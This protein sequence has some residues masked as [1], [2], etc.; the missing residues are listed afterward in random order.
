MANPTL[1]VTVQLKDLFSKQFKGMAKG[2]A[3]AA[4]S[5]SR[6][7]GRSFNRVGRSMKTLRTSIGSAGKAFLSLKTAAVAIA[8][9]M[10]GRL[11]RGIVSASTSFEGLSIAMSNLTKEAGMDMIA[12]ME[13]LRVATRGAV[14]DNELM[15][16]TNQA[17]L[18]GVIK[19]KEE[20]GA[21]AEAGRR[22]GAAMGISAKY[23]LESLVKG[24]GRQ[25][26]LWLDNLGIL[27]KLEKA[28]ED[29]ARSIGKTVDELTDEQRKTAFRT[30][31]F[32]AAE[33][34]LKTL[35]P[36]V[37]MVSES[38][39]RFSA[40]MSNLGTKL[41]V[42][43][44]PEF[45]KLADTF[46]E[47]AL[48]NYPEM[49]AF[50]TFVLKTL[51]E[52]AKFVKE[53][54]NLKN[55]LG[56]GKDVSGPSMPAIK[57]KVGAVGGPTWAEI[58]KRKEDDHTYGL[59]YIKVKREFG[60]ENRKEYGFPTVEEWTSM[61]KEMDDY[62]KKFEKW[63][64]RSSEDWFGA[65]TGHYSKTV[66]LPDV[67]V[68]L[69]PFEIAMDQ[70]LEAKKAA[71]SAAI[72]FA[73]ET[74]QFNESIWGATRDAVV[75]YVNFTGTVLDQFAFAVT[76]TFGALENTLGN[77]FFDAMTGKMKSFKEYVRSFVQDITSILAQMLAKQAVLGLINGIGGLFAPGTTTTSAGGVNSISPTMP[78]VDF[79]AGGYGGNLAASGGIYDSP[80]IAG[81]AGAEAI[82]PLPGNRKVPVE[83]SGGGGGR[84]VNVSFNIQ[85]NDAGSFRSS[86]A[87]N[88]DMLTK[89]FQ[90]ALG[91]DAQL[92][93][94][95]RAV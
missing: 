58:N 65:Q 12:T 49:V 43:V 32:K 84:V 93:S 76:D 70:A 15:R 54:R 48:D 5:M 90:K 19:S 51:R 37:V 92:R 13:G 30:A 18:L 34:K 31:A 77:V 7:V 10:T 79:N 21:L 55:I 28:Q 20:M 42:E 67:E 83:L 59:R 4:K 17:L 38:F 50:L 85:T 69:G 81:E 23:G 75:D 94:T 72:D 66:K 11:V 8:A 27:V 89:I 86:L 35:G 56:G 64:E 91:S 29:Y 62:E 40:T 53:L 63:K 41:S 2:S 57:P 14:D 52:S 80:V 88:Q 26:V 45:A 16:Q 87:Q 36:D 1:S 68:G 78:G 22:L 47:L 60:I 3:T 82:I 73:E 95:V 74:R 24:I 33:D 44:A 6:T 46:T 61:Q 71:A 39:A 9:Y 25:S